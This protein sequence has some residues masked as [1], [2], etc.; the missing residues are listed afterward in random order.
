MGRGLAGH[1]RSVNWVFGDSKMRLHTLFCLKTTAVKRHGLHLSAE[2][3]RTRSASRGKEFADKRSRRD[4]SAS[5]ERVR[6]L[7]PSA[8]PRSQTTESRPS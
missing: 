2:Q 4:S 1:P 6:L 8:H 7:Q 5:S 3:E